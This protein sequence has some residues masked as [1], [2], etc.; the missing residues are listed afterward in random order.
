VLVVQQFLTK[1]NIPVFTQPPY[2]PYLA[3]PDFKNSLQ[4]NTFH[5]HGGYK[6]ECDGGTQNDTFRW[7]S[8][9]L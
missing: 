3:D 1:K 5:N 8:Q 9:Q 6:I 4:G 7:C 2:S